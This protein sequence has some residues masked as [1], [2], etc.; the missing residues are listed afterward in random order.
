MLRELEAEGRARLAEAG[1]ARRDV[2]VERTADM[3]LV[4]QMHEIT[5]PLPA[6]RIGDGE[7]R[8]DPRRP[9][10]EAYSARYTSFYDG[11]RIEAINFRVRCRRA[12]ARSSR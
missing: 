9:S 6:G 12:D 5:V 10:R 7:P 2:V 1:V 8:R 11:A 4:G 3:R